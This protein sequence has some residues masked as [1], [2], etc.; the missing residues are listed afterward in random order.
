MLYKEIHP[1]FPAWDLLPKDTLNK[2]Y[3]QI[4]ALMGKR[5]CFPE[6]GEKRT[7]KTYRYMRAVA[8][9]IWSKEHWK[10]PVKIY[11]LELGPTEREWI[12]AVIVF[13]HGTMPI[14]TTRWIYSRGYG[15]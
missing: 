13:Y 6:A 11:A 8:Q 2:D 14:E 1:E 5:M 9:A 15:C 10:N 3:Q 4:I 12:K 7:N